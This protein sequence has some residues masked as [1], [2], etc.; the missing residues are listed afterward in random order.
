MKYFTLYNELPRSR[1]ARYPILFKNSV[2][3]REASP[4][5]IPQSLSP[6]GGK[7]R[8]RYIGLLLP[9]PGEGCPKDKKGAFRNLQ[10]SF[11]TPKQSFEEFF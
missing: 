5:P 3:S 10:V 11:F 9:S 6:E 8:R 1:D 7:G 4:P 2:V